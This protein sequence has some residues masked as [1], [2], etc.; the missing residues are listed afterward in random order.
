MSFIYSNPN[1]SGIGDRIFDLILV[2][3][4]ANFLNYDK[5]YLHWRNNNNDIVDAN[6][7]YHIARKTLTPFREKDYLLE[8]LLNYLLLPK[9][10]IFVTL[11][12][13]NK[14][15]NDSSNFIFDNYMGLQYSVYDF[16]NIF[17][18]NI[19]NQQKYEFINSYFENFKKIK[20]NNIPD[21]IID[22]FNNNEIITI[23]LRRG[24]KV[25]DDNCTTNNIDNQNLESLN[26]NTEL[27]INKCI[28]LNYKNICF[29]SD[30]ESVKKKFI[31]K[32]KDK[33]N[34]INCEGNNISQTYIDL[35]CL[36]KSKKILLSQKFSVFS[37]LSSMIGSVD[38]YYIYNDGK[39][40]RNNFKNYYN[41]HHYMDL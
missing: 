25:I 10:I 3:T 41:F 31:N 38:Y 36:S 2:Y 16:I 14:L 33:C 6:D 19:T 30:E 8:N 4:Y 27:F 29:V 7:I 32:F 39:I 34:I 5:I 20:F 17:L 18:I 37:M 28:L 11:D 35:Y 23:H 12:E 26:N 21:D 40:I 13:I 24:D 1:L 15:K 9:N 22:K